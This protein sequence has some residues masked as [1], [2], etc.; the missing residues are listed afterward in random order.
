ME[1]NQPGSDPIREARRIAATPA[2]QELVRLLQRT[3]GEEL[4]QAMAKAAA[5]DYSA[6]QKA[7]SALLQDPEA[8]KLMN[9]LGR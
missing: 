6:A 8:Q 5:G 3:G 9:Q 7:L 1:R 4:K 2:G